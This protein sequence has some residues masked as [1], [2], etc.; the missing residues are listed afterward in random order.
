MKLATATGPTVPLAHAPGETARRQG[1]NSKCST[2]VPRPG[3]P[4][5]MLHAGQHTPV[6]RLVGEP[7]HGRFS[8]SAFLWRCH[9]LP[10]PHLIFLF[11]PLLQSPG[12]HLPYLIGPRAPGHGKA[13]GCLPS[14]AISLGGAQQAKN[15]LMR[16]TFDNQLERNLPSSNHLRLQFHPH[17]LSAAPFAPA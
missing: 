13:H 2:F 11:P 17:Y 5:P 4:E 3:A 7:K 9:I 12:L 8:S 16:F 1:T 15:P 10:A 14:V 6:L